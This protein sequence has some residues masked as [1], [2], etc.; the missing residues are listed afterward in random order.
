MK[1]VYSL[2]SQGS[3]TCLLH[4]Q[5]Y[6]ITYYF[7][8]SNE[9]GRE[10]RIKSLDMLKKIQLLLSPCKFT[11]LG[12]FFKVWDGCY[13]VTCS[14]QSWSLSGRRQTK[15]G[16]GTCGC[17][18][19]KSAKVAS[20]SYL[21]CREPFTLAPLGWTWTHTFMISTSANGH[22]ILYLTLIW[23][24]LRLWFRNSM[25]ACWNMNLVGE[26]CC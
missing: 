8:L 10:G 18:S 22:S 4:I 16:T 20:A 25:K 9:K 26:G 15:P 24:V 7:F 13:P 3:L 21:T 12:H 5:I 1:E 17:V 6:C 19:A 2:E 14:T 23:S 11:I